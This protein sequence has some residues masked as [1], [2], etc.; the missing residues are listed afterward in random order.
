MNF[1][2]LKR[3]LRFADYYILII[4]SLIIIL[5]IIFIN[6]LANPLL[7]FLAIFF[8]L[9]FFLLLV[10]YDNNDRSIITLLRNLY[11]MAIILFV[12]NQAQVLIA[13]VHP[14]DYDNTL[15]LWDRTILGNDIGKIFEKI[16][17]PYLTEYLQIAYA[18]FYL[19][20]IVIGLEFYNR[21]YKIFDIY[22]RNIL[23]GFFFSFFLYFFMPAIGPRFTV[24]DFNKLNSDL[25]G[26]FLT[27][28]LRSIINFGGGITN[29]TINPAL[30]ANRDCMP[31]G[32]TM[33]SIINMYFAF[34]Y[35][36]KSKWIAALFGVSII[37]ATVY[38]RYHYFIDIIAGA[39]FALISL[40]L[41]PLI[42]KIVIKSV[43]RQ[44][45]F[46]Q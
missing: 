21:H 46:E 1:E 34:K 17:N 33:L 20:F 31:S 10:Y 29:N 42:H 14:I 35:R 15:I 9:F 28:L 13:T 41:E 11:Y 39:L 8:E 40:L 27:D 5:D 16:A 2:S 3:K 37:F 23:F 25:P 12:Y 45:E 7:N 36:L 19:W 43:K 38:L 6:N 18:S 30:L 32:H 44:P 22:A 24:Y 4:Y 26:L